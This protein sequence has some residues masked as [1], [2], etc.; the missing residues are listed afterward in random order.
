MRQVNISEKSFNKEYFNLADHTSRCFNMYPGEV[1]PIRIKF[2]NHLINAIIDRFGKDV[3]VEIVDES[4]F[5]L[6]TEAALTTGLIRWILNWGSDAE[7]LHP[8]ILV[9]KVREE[10]GKMYQIYHK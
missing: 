3:R 7:V 4:H 6:L 5:V 8:Q 2:D 9:E 1:R 10:T